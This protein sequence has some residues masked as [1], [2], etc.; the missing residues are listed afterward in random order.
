M[1]MTPIVIA[2]SVNIFVLFIAKLRA[3]KKEKKLTI[4][5]G[6]NHSINNYNRIIE[7]S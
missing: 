2:F 7:L 3:K 6:I 4:T 1:S 5:S